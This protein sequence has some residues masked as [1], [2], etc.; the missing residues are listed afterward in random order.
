MAT[1]YEL[2]AAGL[3]RPVKVKISRPGDFEDRSIFGTAEFYSWLHGPVRSSKPF[4]RQDV[5]PAFQAHDLLVRFISGKT[6][7]DSRLF[8]RMIPMSD[9]VWEFSTPD[10]RIFGWFQEKN[11]FIAVKGDFFE[12]LKSDRSLYESHRMECI[13]HRD[14]LD[15]DEPKYL[16]DGNYRDVISD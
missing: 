7:D 11:R 10:L 3:L 5:K 15:L 4:Y 14:A 8:K 12:A 13:A 6:F 16:R 2:V 9:D 1:F